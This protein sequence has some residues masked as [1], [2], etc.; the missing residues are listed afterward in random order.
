MAKIRAGGGRPQPGSAQVVFRARALRASASDGNRRSGTSTRY[1]LSL[2]VTICR[3]VHRDRSEP[4]D[5]PGAYGHTEQGFHR[6]DHLQLDRD[7]P[8]VRA[9]PQPVGHIR[10][11]L[12]RIAPI[13]IAGLAGEPADPR[14]HTCSALSTTS[15]QPT[16]SRSC[17]SRARLRTSRSGVSCS[18]DI[19][20]D[21]IASTPTDTI[22]SSP[23]PKRKNRQEKE[24]KRKK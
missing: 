13:T 6:R 2:R 7:L 19:T 1:P 24:T 20:S 14:A 11:P 10:P 3:H 12:P 23:F 16:A 15:N 9:H 21:D 22:T 8:G 18:G 4:G 5:L 17:T